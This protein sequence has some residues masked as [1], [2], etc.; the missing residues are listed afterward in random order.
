MAQHADLASAVVAGP[1]DQRSLTR[2]ETLLARIS[3]QK[4]PV[5]LELDYKRGREERL[6]GPKQ[7]TKGPDKSDDIG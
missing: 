4:D 1:L 5:I 6:S 7:Q 2:V 3:G